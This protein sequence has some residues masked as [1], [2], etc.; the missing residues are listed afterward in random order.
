MFRRLA[1]FSA[2]FLVFGFG[3]RAQAQSGGPL[4]LLESAHATLASADHDYNG[5]RVA[6]MWQVEAAAHELE[7]VKAGRHAE[8]HYRTRHVRHVKSLEPQSVSDAK[9]RNAASLLQ[10]AASGMSGKSLRHL[11]DALAQLNTALNIR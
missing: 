5:H 6:A 9:L 10:Q 8:L 11:N 7:G 4:G 2:V 1:L 3:L